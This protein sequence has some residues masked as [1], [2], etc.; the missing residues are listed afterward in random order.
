VDELRDR[1]LAYLETP[2]KEEAPAA[3]EKPAAEE[4][5]EE[6]AEGEEKEEEAKEKAFTPKAKPKLDAATRELLR[7]RK[8]IAAKRPAFHRQEWFRH[9]R[10]GDA[11]RK[12]QG[13]HSKLRRH[14]GY[15]INVVS[16]GYRGPKGVRGFH[17]SGF[18][19]VLV[20]TVRELD[21]VDPNVQAV[22]IAGSVGAR[23]RAVI[24]SAADEKGIRVLNRRGEE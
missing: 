11:W 13:M 6:E 23:K 15:R 8:A 19:E 2:A 18:R 7:V 3:E 17:P 24:E 5:A 22:R 9:A 16:I 1:I 10:L 4:P 14:R 21:S 20:H 12:P